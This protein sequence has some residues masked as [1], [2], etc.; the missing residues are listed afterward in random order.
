MLFPFTMVCLIGCIA[1]ARSVD[2]ERSPMVLALSAWLGS[3]IL[4][5]LLF[6]YNVG[7]SL[8]ADVFVAIGLAATTF[9]YLLVRAKSRP[10][11][12]AYPGQ[13]LDIRLAQILGVIGILGCLFLLAEARSS[14]KSLSIGYLLA[15]LGTIRDKQFDALGSSAVQSPLT[16]VGTYL[17]SCSY[18]AVVAA[19]RLG[20][21]GGLPT[22]AGIN[23]AL[24]TAASLLLYGGRATLFNLAL[25]V[26][27]SF[28][29]GRRR[30]VP[31]QPRTLVIAVIASVAIWYF[32]VPW[33]INRETGR[34]T[35]PKA[36]LAYTQRAELR[37]FVGA[38]A[39]DDRVL[40]TA[41]LSVGYFTSPL[42]TLGFYV[43]QDPLPGPLWGAY[44]YPLPAR[45]LAKFT[46]TASPGMWLESRQKVFAPFTGAGYFPNVWSTLLRDLLVE[47]GYIGATAFCA[48][49][50]AFLAL[51]RNA[52]ERTGQLS[53]HYLE[54]YACFT[55]AFGA[56]TSVLNSTLLSTSFI[57]A[58]LIML[59]T[60]IGA[61]SLLVPVKRSA[62]APVVPKVASGVRR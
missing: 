62:Q 48:G 39:G 26:L 46:G 51:A 14:G 59:G 56:F 5:P 45:T 58:M 2:N 22:L 27:T 4:G 11:P 50:G 21:V 57:V 61:F 6:R 44:S 34:N 7:Y 10:V 37:P 47:F 33:L 43:Q 9:A 23:F 40:G 30:L 19:A 60:R 29:V 13:S 8:K 35:N 41:L 15:N 18:L 49:L 31:R 3:V 54:I 28:Y 16:I 42:P 38:L 32:S 20:R 1:A 12:K 36:I 55:L 52:F 53:Y 25:L 24:I 17:A